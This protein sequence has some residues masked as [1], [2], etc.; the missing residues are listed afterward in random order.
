M[1]V[2][3]RKWQGNNQRENGWKFSWIAED[4]ISQIQEAKKKI[5]LMQLNGKPTH[6]YTIVKLKKT[7]RSKDT[8]TGTTRKNSHYWQNI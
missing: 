8:D 3:E 2:L 1:E 4:S 5:F 6:I 7:R